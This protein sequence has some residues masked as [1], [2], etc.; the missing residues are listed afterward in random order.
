MCKTILRDI[1]NL[2]VKAKYASLAG[3]PSLE[4]F[5]D[6]LVEQISH[7]IRRDTSGRLTLLFVVP[8]SA[9]AVAKGFQQM[10]YLC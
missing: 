3:R 6:K 7:K 10:M 2:K 1:Y 4:A 9:L 8:N 5:L